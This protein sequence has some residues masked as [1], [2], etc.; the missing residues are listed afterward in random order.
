M[1]FG[2]DIE[3]W[4]TAKSA[5]VLRVGEEIHFIHSETLRSVLVVQQGE[6][7][8]DKAQVHNEELADFYRH[9]VGGSIC[10]GMLIFA[11]AVKGG[12]Q[13]SVG[14]KLPDF[15]EVKKI[16]R[17]HQLNVSDDDDVFLIGS[18]WM[19][20]Y[21][22]SKRPNAPLRCYDRDYREIYEDQ[23]LEQVLSETWSLMNTK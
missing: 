2:I 22:P 14:H 12:V 21:A 13:L 20:F 9:Y 19:F 4:L 10:N 8:G 6:L 17:E 3:N 15:D 16:A 1:P 11:C 5:E 23:T 7:C 18:A